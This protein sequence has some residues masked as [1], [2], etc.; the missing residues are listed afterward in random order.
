MQISRYVKNEF[1]LLIK[2]IQMARFR[3]SMSG[4]E[5]DRNEV[6]ND[7]QTVRKYKSYD[8]YVRHQ[9]SK[10]RF[11]S[12]FKE[13]RVAHFRTEFY[14]SKFLSEVRE[15]ETV[16]CVGARFGEEVSVL[17]DM[18]YLAIGIDLNPKL[19]NRFVLYGDVHQLEFPN[20]VFDKVFCN[21][22][23]HILDIEKALSEIARVLKF[24]GVLVTHIQRQKPGDFE[25]RGWDSAEQFV[26]RIGMFFGVHPITTERGSFLEAVFLLTGEGQT[27]GH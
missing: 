24:N 16:L 14:Q 5:S 20:K 12:G 11:L 19:E 10:A 9:S 27:R 21:I 17:R 3:W 26:Q 13:N 6:S 25:A 8:H 1:R 4:F 15:N 18:G 2:R 23:D 7:G 22:L